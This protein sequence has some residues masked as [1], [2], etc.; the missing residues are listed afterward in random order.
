MGTAARST[1][2]NSIYII[3]CLGDVDTEKTGRDLFKYLGPLCRAAQ[4]NISFAAAHSASEV[5]DILRE[6]AHDCRTHARGPI[7]HLETHGSA[8]GFGPSAADQVPWKTLVGPLQ[9]LNRLSQMNLVV[10]V[11]ACHGFSLVSTLMPGDA[12]PVWGLL[13]PNEMVLP[14]DIKRGFQ[15]FYST[16]LRELNLNR[17]IDELKR[18]DRSWPECWTFQNAEVFFATVFGVVLEQHLAF[19]KSDE[20]ETQALHRLRQAG[21][22]ITEEIRERLRAVARDFRGAYESTRKTFLMLDLFPHNSSRFPLSLDEIL[23]I[24]GIVL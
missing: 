16:Y 18:A 8:S 4:V 20:F 7:V 2:F 11:A 13:G 22:E 24:K 6:I 19:G 10:T 23:A 12:S 21:V 15:A 3:E 1:F 14:S 9:E 17:A 5:A